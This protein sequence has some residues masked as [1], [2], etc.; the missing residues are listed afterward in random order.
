MS[1]QPLFYREYG[2]G[3]TT[4][5]ILHGL[6]GLCDNW[7]TLSR[8][9][10][11]DFHTLAV[12]M[13]NHGQS[14]WFDDHD[15]DLMVR[16]VVKLI[17]SL[18]STK[19][20]LMGHSMGGK[21]A[22]LLAQRHLELIE[23]LI[24]VDISPRYYPPH[25]ADVVSAISAID[26]SQHQRRNTIG[27]VLMEHLQDIDTTNFLLKNV[28]RNESGF[29]W[30]FNKDVIVENIN[31]I[32]EET[33]EGIYEGPT[34]FVKG[35]QSGY[36]SDSDLGDI[37]QCFP[38]SEVKAIENAGHWVHAANPAGFYQAVMDFVK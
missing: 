2:Q 10:A 29:S 19:V 20:Y 1:T 21:A 5:V 15:Y 37:K 26:F 30:R 24:V 18:P 17:E 23:K 3:G 12:D 34:L 11:E 32:G 7:I 31:D 8:Q 4:L 35:E 13:P 6:F 33:M 16:E 22:M 28:Q 9:F 36:I 25:H 27:E 14:P 38:Y